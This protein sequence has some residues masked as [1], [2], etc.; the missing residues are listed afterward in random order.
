M[1]DAWF[2]FAADGSLSVWEGVC[3]IRHADGVTLLKETK[4]GVVEIAIPTSP[5]V[6]IT[7]DG[8]WT[9]AEL[10]GETSRGDSFHFHAIDPQNAVTLL[11][12]ASSSRP[13]RLVVRMDP[14]PLRLNDVPS[15]LRR[16]ESWLRLKTIL[17]PYEFNLILDNNMPM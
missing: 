16:I 12:V 13:Q 9:C 3:G 15:T 7:S 11:E 5:K 8:Y 17:Q 14:D 4:Y 1:T 10:T 6:K 2:E